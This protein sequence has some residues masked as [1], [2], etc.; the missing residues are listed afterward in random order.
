[1][2][3]M[4]CQD[5]NST[6]TRWATGM[7]WGWVPFHFLYVNTWTPL[8]MTDLAF[9][10]LQTS[11]WLAAVAHSHPKMHPRLLSPLATHSVP[12]IARKTN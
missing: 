9:K 6:G 12:T 5:S 8:F 7:I 1:M 2:F 4:V 11:S 10:S 3:V